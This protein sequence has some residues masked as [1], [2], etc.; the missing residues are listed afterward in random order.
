MAKPLA[1]AAPATWSGDTPRSIASIR[2]CMLVAKSRIRTAVT[3]EIM[4]RPYWAA[5]PES[6]RSWTTS[7]LV[8]RADGARV[9]G[10]EHRGLAAALLIGAG[11]VDDDALGRIVALDN[12]CGAGE[13]KLDR[14]H[15]DADAAEVLLLTRSSLT[16]R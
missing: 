11:R 6:C 4:P 1:G 5:A 9:R 10:D 3:S 13:L 16:G 2:V 12:R 8:P 7:T 15:P 14:T